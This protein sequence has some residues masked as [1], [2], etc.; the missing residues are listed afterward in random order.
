MRIKQSNP[1]AVLDVLTNEVK[2]K[3][4]FSGAAWAPIMVHVPD[5]LFGRKALRRVRFFR[6]AILS[7]MWRPLWF[8]V[9][10]GEGLDLRV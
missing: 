7:P 6:H 2:K 3:G 8:A 1:T 5:A 9:V 10:R 4:G